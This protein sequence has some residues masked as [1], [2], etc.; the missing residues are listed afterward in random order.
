MTPIR[1]TPATRSLP[2]SVSPRKLAGALLA[3]ALSFGGCATLEVQ[4]VSSGGATAEGGVR[5]FLPKPYLL[6]RPAANRAGSSWEVIYLPDYDRAFEVS[7]R[8]F[9]SGVSVELSQGLFLERI[10]TGGGLG[11]YRTTASRPAL[12][13]PTAGT[14]P[15]GSGE[16]LDLVPGLYEIETRGGPASGVKLVRIRVEPELE[17]RQV[18][19][20]SPQPVA[21]SCCTGCDREPT[22]RNGAP[23]P[24]AT[25]NFHSADG[26]STDRFVISFQEGVADPADLEKSEVLAV[27]DG[28]SFPCGFDDK[29]RCRLS[30]QEPRYRRIAVG[31]LPGPAHKAL[32]AVVPSVGDR[33]GQPVVAEFNGAPKRVPKPG[34]LTVRDLEVRL[35]RR[36]DGIESVQLTAYGPLVDL[37]EEGS[38]ESTLKESGM[39]T[40][41]DDSERAGNC[42]TLTFARGE[43]DDQGRGLLVVEIDSLTTFDEPFA[44]VFHLQDRHGR[45]LLRHPVPLDPTKLRDKAEAS[46][47]SPPATDGE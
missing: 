1:P 34:R 7:G 9:L 44:L 42:P 32:V 41:C 37:Y 5:F 2:Y 26:T 12:R 19:E 30:W 11:G 46:E 16:V 4:E 10:S 20:S 24:A 8:S 40:L 27:A 23:P 33:T 21:Q 35:T 3:A 31:E 17:V 25:L 36:F 45:T 47:P 18:K 39:A 14:S 38:R 6:V 15:A 22:P 28:R 29:H 13:A 43:E